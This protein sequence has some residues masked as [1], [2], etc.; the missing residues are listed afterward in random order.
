MA[1]CSGD[2]HETL[3]PASTPNETLTLPQNTI[4]Y[5]APPKKAPTCTRYSG[6]PRPPQTHAAASRHPTPRAF[7]PL[8]SGLFFDL[9]KQE[10]PTQG[11]DEGPCD[12]HRA[13]DS[14]T[15]CTMHGPKR[16]KTNGGVAATQPYPTLP[17]AAWRF[18]EAR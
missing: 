16:M 10:S 8:H 7:I 15:A 18:F 14:N 2:A 13:P 6:A 9:G 4:P 3:P 5:V 1:G 17:F 11:Y 12:P